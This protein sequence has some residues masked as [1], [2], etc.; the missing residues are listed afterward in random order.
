MMFITFEGIDGVG[1]TT[2]S[3]LLF[4]NLQ[5][6]GWSVELTHEPGGTDLGMKVRQIIKTETNLSTATQFHLIEAQRHHHVDK[7][8][9]TN[10]NKGKVVICDRFIDTTYVYQNSFMSEF[11][12]HNSYL[13]GYKIIPDLTFLMYTDDIPAIKN[14]MNLRSGVEMD[15]F[16]NASIE[17]LSKMQELFFNLAWRYP[18]IVPINTDGS[19]ETIS[20]TIFEHVRKKLEDAVHPQET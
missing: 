15:W 5:Y 4:S 8:I 20:A 3:Q 17:K 14:R 19:V 13:T 12:W 9:L 6:D 11:K 18:R 10:L 7:F 2:Q 16:D 1:K